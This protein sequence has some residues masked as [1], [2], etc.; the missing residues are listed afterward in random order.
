MKKT[1]FLTVACIINAT[2]AFAGLW[3]SSGSTG[4]GAVYLADCSGITSGFCIDTDDGAIYYW[5]GSAVVASGGSGDY[6]LPEASGSVLGGIKIGSGLS[7]DG[8]GVASTAV[9][10]TNALVGSCTG[11]PCLDGTSDGGDFIKLYGGSGFWTALQAGAPAANRSWRLPIAAAPSAGTTRLLNMDENGQMG[12][13]DPATYLTPSGVGA[14]LTVTATGFNGNLTTDDNTLQEIAQA[15]D[16]LTIGSASVSDTVYGAGWNGDTTTAPSKN[17]VYDKIE[18][19]AAG[20]LPTVT[21]GQILQG[22]SSGVLVATSSFAG[23]I[24]DSG[25]GTDDLWSASKIGTALGLKAPVDA[26]TFTNKVT[27]AASASGGAGFNLPHGAAPSSPVNGDIWT[28]SAGGL[29]ARINGSTVGPFGVGGS[30]TPDDTP[31]DNDTTNPPT[32]NW[33]Y[34]HAAL[35]MSDTVVG[36]VE[37]ATTAETTT[38][39]STSLAVTPD[40]LSGSVYG[41]KEIGWSVINSDTVTAVADGKQAAVVPA[42][43]NGMDLIDL[44]CSVH[45]LNSAA[46]GT[47][48]VVL[49]RVRG[50]TAADMTSTGVTIG[51]NEY[52]ASDETV[53]TSNDDLQ[54]GDKLYIDINAVTSAAQKGLSCTALFQT[55]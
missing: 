43:M 3:G 28:T 16:D 6:T 52:T 26:P 11:L 45:D 35:A 37:A 48:T 54:T 53:D 9:T 7:I 1:I 8:N 5:N 27:T 46:S 44:T 51:Y 50:N 42:S 21:E 12:F 40:G 34:D 4:S 32:A 49:R 47:T 10:A 38:G 33:A 15:L 29:Y 30:G 31:N 39:T 17:A 19:I 23:L 13:V 20:A 14:A 25:T 22:N 36:H 18:T 24:N 55:P 41:Q 2:V